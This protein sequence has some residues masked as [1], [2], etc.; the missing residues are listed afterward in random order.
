MI[1]YRPKPG[2]QNPIVSDINLF[3][4]RLYPNRSNRARKS[5]ILRNLYVNTRPTFLS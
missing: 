1:S 5:L 3:V 4:A 2:I